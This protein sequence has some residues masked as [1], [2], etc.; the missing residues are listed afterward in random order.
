M[1]T[2]ILAA[3]LFCTHANAAGPNEWDAFAK[4]VDTR[5]TVSAAHARAITR[6]SSTLAGLTREQFT[7]HLVEAYVWFDYFSIPQDREGADEASK[8][9]VGGKDS[10]P[11]SSG[12]FTLVSPKSS[13]KGGS[14]NSSS[15]VSPKLSPQLRAIKSIPYYIERATYFVVVAPT[16]THLVT[17]ARCDLESWRSRGWCRLE[18]LANYLAIDRM[19]P[20]VLTEGMVRR[21]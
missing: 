6:S 4:G 14:R 13:G 9:G 2:D 3:P 21:P 20:V 18:E 12:S 11:E 5:K 16:T 19:N 17:K 8:T 7:H 1:V 10:D 15:K